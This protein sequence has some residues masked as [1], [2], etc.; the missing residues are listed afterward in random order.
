M[1]RQVE[2]VEKVKSYDPFVEEEL[3]VR[4]PVCIFYRTTSGLLYYSRLILVLPSLLFRSWWEEWC[5]FII[6]LSTFILLAALILSE[7]NTTCFSHSC[8]LFRKVCETLAKG[9]FKTVFSFNVSKQK[10][11]FEESM[12]FVVVEIENINKYIHLTLKIFSFP[13]LFPSID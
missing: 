4:F 12:R 13:Y 2:L 6:V 1:L 11:C 9:Y 3:L 5:S 10:K 7:K 8:F